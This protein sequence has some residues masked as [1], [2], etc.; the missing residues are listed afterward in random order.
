PSSTVIVSV[1]NPDINAIESQGFSV[2]IPFPPPPNLPSVMFDYVAYA[3]TNLPKHY[4][5]PNSPAGNL[6]GTDNTPPTNP[7]TNAGATLGRVLFY[8]TFL[9]ANNTTSCGSRHLQGFGFVDP[10][11][12]SSVFQFG[13]T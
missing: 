10:R 13:L 1:R 5:D 4:T 7:I 9:S 3:V 12:L 2:L 8:D 11:Q 6:A